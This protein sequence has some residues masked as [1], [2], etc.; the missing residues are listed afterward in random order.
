VAVQDW[1]SLSWPA[2][3]DVTGRRVVAVLPL[4]AIEAHGPHLPLGT[5]VIIAEAMARA[6]AERLSRH[7]L[8]AVLLPA[9]PFAPAPFAAGFA[10]SIDT[11][12]TAT[13]A[14]IHGVA[15]SASQ[16]GIALTVIANA[17]HDPAHV[18]AI[19]AAVA[20]VA[21]QHP[22]VFPDLTRR[23]WASRL[24]PEFQS[25]ACHAGRYEG[26]VMLAAAPH[27]VDEARMRT[28]APN[29]QSLVDAIGRGDRT[30]VA[31]GGAEA[32]FGWPAEAS[33]DEGRAIIEALGAIIEE[34]V[35]E[36]TTSGARS[37]RKSVGRAR[38]SHL[39]VVNPPALAP[40]R[41]FSHGVA[42]APGDT[43]LHVAGQTAAG[44][45][46]VAAGSFVE[47]FERALI[48]V[49]AVVQ[50]AGGHASDVARMR[51]YVT[52]MHEYRSSRSALA[53]VWRRHMGRHYP[54]MALVAVTGLVEEGARVEIEA[55]AHV[56][57]GAR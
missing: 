4:G 49:L 20:A 17:H 29:P 54:A 37:D 2:F 28:L 55:D 39:V 26:S 42:A 32:Y 35:L 18:A 33:A 9:M 1:A 10:G 40:P 31:A 12:A 7:G 5:D 6:G 19:R 34:A 38:E 24:T 44:A 15:A 48:A 11:P 53:D 43:F 3:R 50:S 23:R 8:E 57:R 36:E 51:I 22:V 47:Q 21:G 14:I 45:D 27:L 46:G 41:G 16:H 56:A 25:G 13:A 30:F 52:D